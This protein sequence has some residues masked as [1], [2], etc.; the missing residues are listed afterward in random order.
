MDVMCLEFVN[1]QWYRKHEIFVEQLED[2]VWLTAFCAKWELPALTVSPEVVA[3]L[4]D[5]RTRFHQILSEL[6][7]THA[8][9]S[10]NLAIINGYLNLGLAKKELRIKKG[11]LL[12]D[13]V[14]Q[15]STLDWVLY[16]IALSLAELLTSYPISYLK[17]CENP[18]CD[19]FF[20]DVSKN[21]TRKW[22]GNTCASLMKV[23]KHRAQQRTMQC[24]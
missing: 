10:K 17:E 14:S 20:Y 11:E 2:P 22:C 15:S 13:S 23:R 3:A 12:I 18:D 5:L 9:S 1:S 7:S 16:K 19:W 24:E 21:H 4:L 8:V 6:C